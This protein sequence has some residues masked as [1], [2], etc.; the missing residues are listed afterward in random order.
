[1][2]RLSPEDAAA[3]ALEAVP[4]CCGPV[5]PVPLGRLLEEQQVLP[6]VEIDGLSRASVSHYLLSE[7]FSPPDLGQEEKLAGFLFVAGSAGLIFVN[8]DADN[9]LGRRRFTAAHELGHFLMQ[10]DRM[11]ADRW[12]GDAPKVIREADAGEGEQMERKANRFAALVLMPEALCRSRDGEFRARHPGTPGS[13]LVHRL[14]ADLL[15]SRQA[16]TFRL[17]ELGLIHDAAE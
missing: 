2:K 16:L 4:G 17:Q 14:T 13:V 12:H 10:H 5:G 9:P 15:V 1:M 8:S 3:E 7:G 6:A 11:I